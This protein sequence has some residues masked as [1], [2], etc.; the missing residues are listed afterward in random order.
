MAS[1]ALEASFGFDASLASAAMAAM[2]DSGAGAGASAGAPSP[3]WS[4]VYTV[5]M[6]NLPNKYTQQMLLEELNKSGFLGTFDFLYLP[7]DPETNANRGYAFI[8]FIS[9]GSAWLLRMT[10]EGR[11]MSR[12]NSDKVVSVSPA[13]LQGFEANYAHYST[14]RCSRG[15]VAARPLFLRSPAQTSSHRSGQRR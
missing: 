9:P 3:E 2:Q 1:T 7:I 12:F 6:R 10:Y 5:M 13:A 8:N 11:K 4:D 14:A 15:S